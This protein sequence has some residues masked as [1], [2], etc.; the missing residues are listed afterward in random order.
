MIQISN[1]E[2][3]TISSQIGDEPVNAEIIYDDALGR[4]SATVVATYAAGTY[5]SPTN[6]DIGDSAGLVFGRDT[7]GHFYYKIAPDGPM[8]YM[9]KVL[10]GKIVKREVPVLKDGSKDGSKDRPAEHATYEPSVIH[11][12]G[13]VTRTT[14]ADLRAGEYVFSFPHDCDMFARNARIIIGRVLM[15]RLATGGISYSRAVVDEAFTTSHRVIGM[16]RNMLV[17]I[18]DYGGLVLSAPSP[19]P[20]PAPAPV[21][22]LPSPALDV[23]SSLGR[24]V[25]KHPGSVSTFI[26]ETLERKPL[27]VE[28]IFTDG[29]LRSL[30]M[31]AVYDGGSYSTKSTD[32]RYVV[33]AIE[34]AMTE[35]GVG[36][37]MYFEIVDGA[38]VARVNHRREIIEIIPFFQKVGTSGPVIN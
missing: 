26:K 18:L 5:V 1:I 27:T 12:R 9:C 37:T 15:S 8:N 16:T 7:A 17:K 23:D 25:P 2:S 3:T 14:G 22:Q 36:F 21:P 24:L 6:P 33:N 29:D 31:S 34:K 19:A 10:I 30:R 28:V 38:L 35:A 13:P 11:H 20:S 32:E 4:R